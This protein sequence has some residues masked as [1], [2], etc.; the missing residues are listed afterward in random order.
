ME[1]T[2]ACDGAQPL[3]IFGK[4]AGEI[5]FP[6][7][8]RP[9]LDVSPVIDDMLMSRYLQLIGVLGWAIQLGKIYII[10]EVSVISQHQ[11]QPR[12]GR[13]AAVY[14]VFWYLKHNLKEISGRIVFDYK[15]T[16]I[17]EQLFRPS[18]NIVWEELYPDTEEA[19][20]GNALH[21]R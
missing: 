17:D 7:N 13:L 21:S 4:K 3:K 1:D 2:L 11:C 8:Y 9:V 10:A 15:I 12:E 20:P 5:R 16:D 19:I 14:C 18:N 6:S